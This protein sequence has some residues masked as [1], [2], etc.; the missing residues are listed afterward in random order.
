MFCLFWCVAAFRLNNLEQLFCS[1]M[2]LHFNILHRFN[3]ST[4][5]NK[6]QMNVISN[7]SNLIAQLSLRTMWHVTWH[8]ARDKRSMCCTWFAHD[9]T[10][11]TWGY[12][13][14]T[15]RG[16]VRRLWKI[17]NCTLECDYYYLLLLLLLLFFLLLC[18]DLG[19]CCVTV[20]L[21]GYAVISEIIIIGMGWSFKLKVA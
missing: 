20:N 18:N 15:V 9:C 6:A 11:A 19:L 13:L 3:G 4:N 2:F 21:W 17:S 8:V 16:I 14:E 5:K 12:V 10:R 7:L 1:F